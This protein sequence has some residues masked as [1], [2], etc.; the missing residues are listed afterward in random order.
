MLLPP[1]KSELTI[2]AL[3]LALEINTL[4]LPPAL[5]ERLLAA[6]RIGRALAPMLPLPDV[7][8]SV[9]DVMM[10]APLRMMSAA[11]IRFRELLPAGLIL[12]ETVIGPL[13]ASPMD[14]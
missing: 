7:K 6:V 5:A 8:A 10:N 1:A 13:F 3:L 14:K 9:V 12:A 4:P 11:E 2:T